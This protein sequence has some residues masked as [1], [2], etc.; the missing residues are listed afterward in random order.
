[1]E[2]GGRLAM[3]AAV[4]LHTALSVKKREDLIPIFKQADS[5]GDGIIAISELVEVSGCDELMSILADAR[6]P[7]PPDVF[8]EPDC[9]AIANPSTVTSA[10]LVYAAVMTA[11][12]PTTKSL[13]HNPA[14]PPPPPAAPAN[15]PNSRSPAHQP[16]RARERCGVARRPAGSPP[17]HV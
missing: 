9:P 3:M 15:Q 8:R 7:M 13:T 5:N 17:E 6:C 12:S 16:V 10:P 14:F 11:T 4:H 2:K 1:M